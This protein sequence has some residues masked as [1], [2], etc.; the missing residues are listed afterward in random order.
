MYYFKSLLYYFTAYEYIKIYYN[1]IKHRQICC[2]VQDGKLK[3]DHHKN[4]VV[5]VVTVVA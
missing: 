5:V 2:P 3:I 1:I 4:N